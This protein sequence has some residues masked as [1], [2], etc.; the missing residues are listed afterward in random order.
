MDISANSS[1]IRRRTYPSDGPREFW[2]RAD[3]YGRF[4]HDGFDDEFKLILP[5]PETGEF[6]AP[7]QADG[8]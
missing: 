7:T 1:V 4:L 8:C 3:I 2:R 6:E 5:D